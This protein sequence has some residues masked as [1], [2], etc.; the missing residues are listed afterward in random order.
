MAKTWQFLETD[1]SVLQEAFELIDRWKHF[2]IALIVSCL[3][4][5]SSVLSTAARTP[6]K[7][8][9]LFCSFLLD[10]EIREFRV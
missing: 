8:G 3:L 1:A 7:A 10:I 9:L 5:A 2:L 4:T 6:P